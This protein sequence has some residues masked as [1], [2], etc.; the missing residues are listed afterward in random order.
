VGRPGNDP[1]GPRRQFYRLPR[2]LNG[3]PPQY[4]MVS[5]SSPTGTGRNLLP[6][7]RVLAFM[8]HCRSVAKRKTASA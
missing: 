4:V 6:I 7:V 8:E 3:L 5:D 2:L 1:G